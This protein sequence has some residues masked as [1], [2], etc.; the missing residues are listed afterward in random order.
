MEYADSE[1]DQ[2][3]MYSDFQ[4]TI[5]ISWNLARDFLC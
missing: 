2:Q 5:M 3:I 1:G 4:C